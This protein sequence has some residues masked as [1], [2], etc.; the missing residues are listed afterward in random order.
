MRVHL[1]R[2]LLDQVFKEALMVLALVTD[3]TVLLLRLVLDDGR[4]LTALV[5]PLGR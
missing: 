2:R 1:T 5:A 4:G 3:A